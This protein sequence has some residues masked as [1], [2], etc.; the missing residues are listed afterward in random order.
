[1]TR[2]RF[3]V[4]ASLTALLA[5]C[6]GSSDGPSDDPGQ[7]N[8][9][10]DEEVRSTLARDMT[11][12]VSEAEYATFV[13]DTSGFAF[14][15]FGK[16]VAQDGGNGN[17][18]FSPASTSVALAMTYAGANAE[19]RTQ[20]ATA[21]RFTLPDATLHA[22][23]N[24]LLLD[25][26]SRN[27]AKHE[28]EDGPKSLRLHMADAAWAQRSYEFVPSYL[29]TLAVQYGAGVH[30]LDFASDPEG[31][32]SVINDWVAEATEDKILNLLQP[33]AITPNTR[34]VLTN[35]LYFYGSWD[36][37]FLR[38][39]TK[40]APF[41]AAGGDVTVPFMSQRTVLPY[42]EGDG[43][44]AASLP[45]DGHQLAMTFVVPD[46]GRFEQV[47]SAMTGAWLAELDQAMD[48]TDVS[49]LLPKFRFEW[50]STSLK[51]SL[52]ALGMTDAF[53]IDRADFTSMEPKGELFVGDVL[54]KAFIGID[55]DG[56]EAAAAT[57]VVMEAGAVPEEPKKVWADRPFLFMIRDVSGLVLFMGQVTN[58]AEAAQ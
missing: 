40:D 43:Y 12:N 22:A 37:P 11:P 31:S 57:A 2:A 56:T 29:D 24:K 17:M 23:F 44:V 53:D 14:D 26:E 38:E 51:D 45:Y 5:A 19:T 47:R 46:E 6:G 8:V 25:L 39:T 13:G 35:A 3:L 36:S 7:P 52:M 58:P 28:T 33:G 20:M 48:S 50:G 30:I 15:L 9:P 21:L 54:H 42:A 55:E 49:L 27:I 34:L 1:M 18:V 41:H 10:G 32:R 16:L 4:L